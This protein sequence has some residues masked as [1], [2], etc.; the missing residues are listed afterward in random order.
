MALLAE[1]LEIGGFSLSTP[2]YTHTDIAVLLDRADMRTATKIIPGGPGAIAFP[3]RTTVTRKVLPLVIFGDFDGAGNPTS[4]GRAGVEANIAAIHTAVVDPPSTAVSA[5]GT[6][7]AILHLAGGNKTARVRVV[8][9]L[10]LAA[11]AA[12]TYRA[13]LDLEFPYGMFV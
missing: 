6:R 9:P 2:G 8:G 12:S 7:E 4:G 1:W 10:T 5:D 11:F 13:T 3:I